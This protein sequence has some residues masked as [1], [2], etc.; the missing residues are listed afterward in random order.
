MF[1]DHL[2]IFADASIVEDISVLFVKV[3]TVDRKTKVSLTFCKVQV[4][5][6]VRVWV[7]RVLVKLFPV[8]E[9]GKTSPSPPGIFTVPRN[10]QFPVMEQLLS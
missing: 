6:A 2:M 9:M 10:V 4:R 8:I 3:S 5:G 7:V 1:V